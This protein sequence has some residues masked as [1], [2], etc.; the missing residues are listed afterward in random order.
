MKL[1]IPNGVS[2]R[3]AKG[4]VRR[5]FDQTYKLQD[6]IEIWFTPHA[7]YV[8]MELLVPAPEPGGRAHYEHV[9]KQER[10][11]FYPTVCEEIGEAP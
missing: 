5:Y 6:H 2:E 10:Y 9:A 3:M 1:L 11:D 4:L 7:C 8:K